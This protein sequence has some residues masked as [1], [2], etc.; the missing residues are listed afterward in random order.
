MKQL[1]LAIIFSL[2][3]LNV[4][5][6]EL[7]GTIAWYNYDKGYGAIN[8]DDKSNQLTFVYSNITGKDKSL[9][10]GIKVTY[11]VDKDKKVIT[12]TKSK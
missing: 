1:L 3:S 11:T 5:A 8:H 12:V 6:A 4:Y 7:K 9:S 10:K 2:I